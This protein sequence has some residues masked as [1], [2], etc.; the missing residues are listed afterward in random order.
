MSDKF[1]KILHDKLYDLKS[2]RP[3]PA[4]H[5]MQ[6]RMTLV[7]NA[8]GVPPRPR[9][10]HR[11][12]VAYAAA[13]LIA[14]L[15]GLGLYHFETD[16]PER[17]ADIHLPEDSL[18]M[19]LPGIEQ[20]IPVES[21]QVSN[22]EIRS[23][24]GNLFKSAASVSVVTTPQRNPLHNT[25]NQPSL[26]E[27]FDIKLA[28]E[29]LLADE[30]IVRP[31]SM[32]SPT[33]NE[34]NHTARTRA[35]RSSSVSSALGG[36][37][38][39]D[40]YTERRQRKTWQLSAFTNTFAA[41]DNSKNSGRFD[42]P[43]ILLASMVNA[44]Y[45]NNMSNSLSGMKFKHHF[46]ISVG[47]GVKKHFNDRWALETGLVYSYLESTGELESKSF[48]YKARQ[49]VHYL[50]IPLYASYSLFNNHRWDVYLTGGF[51]AE[52][53]LS[54]QQRIRMYFEGDAQSTSYE[55]L[56]PKGL[57]W[58][59]TLGGGVTYYMIDRFGVYLEPGASYYFANDRQPITYRTENPWSFNVRL[60]FRV[61]F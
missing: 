28:S 32:E 60:G 35:D 43:K 25:Q 8:Q 1:E 15:L 4:W 45:L 26:I 50:G 53:G 42:T 55:D 21:L 49:Q 58:S 59:T 18:D 56:H 37:F 51:M 34:R 11:R 52:V 57:L 6:R 39:W 41:S 38:D 47:L 3:V 22:Q 9:M 10:P 61:K 16:T 20:A 13:A 2:D 30:L 54:G 29:S 23:A 31:F 17:L 14:I 36:G 44:D 5:E 12:W 7:E 33:P 40:R 27:N 24:L 48:L 19:T 46:P